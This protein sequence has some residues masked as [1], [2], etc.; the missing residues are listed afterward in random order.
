[1]F[2]KPEIFRSMGKKQ[3]NHDDHQKPDHQELF[4]S[5]WVESNENPL[6]K[7][8]NQGQKIEDLLLKTPGYQEAF[9]S[10]SLL[11]RPGCVLKCSDGRVKSENGNPAIALAGEGLLTVGEDTVILEKVL[12]GKNILITSHEG[13]GAAALAHPGSDSDTY[14]H[15][16]AKSLSA[17]TGS[18]YKEVTHQEFR[19]PV[20]DERFL[21]V[22]GTLRFDCTNW[23]ELPPQFLSSAAGLGLSDKYIETET[24]ALSG[25]A[26]SDHGLG[27][28][29][30]AAN[31]FRVIISAQSYEQLN[32]LL[33]VAESAVKEFGDRIKVD[34]FVAPDK[35]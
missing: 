5:A 29:F 19:S 6:I 1:M 18:N 3:E 30:D 2:H 23:A 13:C 35:N 32:H 25:I 22:D 11:D 17:D 8:L 21:V 20:H 10:V 33:D 28:R 4:N 24:K 12:K 34:G 31:P 27:E 26:L 15:T 7:G 16:K 14:G 9:S